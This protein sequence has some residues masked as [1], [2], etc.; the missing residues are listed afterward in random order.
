MLVLGKVSFIFWMNEFVTK[1]DILV[2]DFGLNILIDLLLLV[3]ECDK[4]ELCGGVHD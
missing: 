3:S 4:I 2:I 1:I